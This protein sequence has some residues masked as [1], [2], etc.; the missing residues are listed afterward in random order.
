MSLILKYSSHYL[1][2]LVTLLALLPDLSLTTSGLKVS[3][4]SEYAKM[5]ESKTYIIKS[6]DTLWWLILHVNM[7]V[8]KN[9]RIRENWGIPTRDFSVKVK[10]TIQRSTRSLSAYPGRGGLTIS[11]YTWGNGDVPCKRVCF[12]IFS[13]TTGCLLTKFS[14]NRVAFWLN[15]P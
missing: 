1:S 6:A 5:F 8:T 2:Q 4:A 11:Y 9:L 7:Y 3:I 10:Q 12:G 15:W 13:L 14:L